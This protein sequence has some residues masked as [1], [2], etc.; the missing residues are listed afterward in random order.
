[1]VRLR[2]QNKGTNRYSRCHLVS[3][4]LGTRA[5]GYSRWGRKKK[6]GRAADKINPFEVTIPAGK[7][8]GGLMG[9]CPSGRQGSDVRK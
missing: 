8:G 2:G 4:D 7:G 6:K 3:G 5:L 1:M 9:K